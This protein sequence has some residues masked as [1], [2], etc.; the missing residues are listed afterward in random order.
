M[1]R[2]YAKLHVTTERG[3]RGEITV[4]DDRGFKLPGVIAATLR[5][6]RGE[7]AVLVLEIIECSRVVVGEARDVTDYN[8]LGA[9]WQ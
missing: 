2:G 9:L 7:R 6:K 3:R 4:R 5:T 1:I 8:D